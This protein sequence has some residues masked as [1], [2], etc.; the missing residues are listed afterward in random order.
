MPFRRHRI[1]LLTLFILNCGVLLSVPAAAALQSLQVG[2]EA[3]EFSLKSVTG[4]TKTLASLKGEKLTVLVFWSTWSAKSEKVLARLQ[5]LHEKYREK[6]LAVVGVDVDGQE[7]GPG[8]LAAI[9]GVQERLKIG[10]P[11]LVD[12]GLVA[13][14]DYGV[15]A[16][17]STV[18]VDRDRVIRYELP[19]FPLVGGEEMVDFVAAAIEGK[20]PPAGVAQKGYQP[21]KSALRL[22]NMGKN[23][24]RSKS[25]ADTAEVW[26]KKSIEA[27]PKFVLP[28]LSLGSFYL[29]RGDAPRALAEFREALAREP[30]NPIALCEA[31]MILATEGKKEEGEA[32]L[33]AARKGEETYAPC[34]TYAGYLYGR[35]GKLAEALRMFDAAEK[36]NPLDYRIYVYKGRVFELRNDPKG[37]ADA[38]RKALELLLPRD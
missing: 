33:A 31:G 9:K 19:G 24:L 6:G 10:F 27:D 32:L 1:L 4:E 8:T 35:E 18:I 34:Y 36:V 16:V 17:P 25:M 37:A 28:Y 38:Y 15:I 21:N 2:M 29:E 23:T 20:K 26:F 30:S 12:Y 14:H 5:T 22:Y 3:P 13:F 11:M 7:I